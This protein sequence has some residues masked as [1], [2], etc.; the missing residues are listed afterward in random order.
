MTYKGRIIKIIIYTLKKSNNKNFL[1]SN[2]ENNNFIR[3]KSKETFKIN[4][5]SLAIK[6]HFLQ[7]LLKCTKLKTRS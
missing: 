5:F 3:I 4:S 1:I 6:L 2:S 7:Y